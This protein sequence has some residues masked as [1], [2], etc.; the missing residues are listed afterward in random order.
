[1]RV[2]AI[3][4]R[5]RVQGLVQHALSVSGIAPPQPAAEALKAAAVRIAQQSLIHAAESLRIQSTLKEA[6]VQALILK[7][8]ALEMLAY[9]RLG[10]K[11]AKDIDVLVAEGHVLRAIH[12]LGAAGYALSQPANLTTDQFATWLRLGRDCELFNPVRGVQVELHWRVVDSDK[13]L[14]RLSVDGPTQLVPVAGGEIATLATEQLFAYLAVH[15]ATH[16]W[17]RLKWLADLAALAGAGG[18]TR[19]EQLHASAV[20]QGAGVCP[21]QALLLA[22]RLVGLDLPEAVGEKVRASRLARW[23][24]DVAL[25]AMNADGDGEELEA[26]SFGTSWISV[27]QLFLTGR[28]KDVPGQ[29]GYRWARGPDL[30]LYVTLPARWRRWLFPWARLFQ[31]VR[32]RIEQLTHRI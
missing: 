8:V 29:I 7:G 21:D 10:V 16:A 23:C 3:A 30:D 31:W 6:G 19:L 22:E 20:D 4:R 28:L 11:H 14:P 27:S 2:E 12:T 5:H 24:A 1:M 15:G 26:K 17:S 18:S 32:R 9:G 13:L 25:R